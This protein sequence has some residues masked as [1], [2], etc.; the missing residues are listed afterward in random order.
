M[1]VAVGHELVSSG[2]NEK[3]LFLQKLNETCLRFY[4]ALMNFCLEQPIVTA[5]ASTFT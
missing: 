2:L 1:A 4:K 3:N 5:A